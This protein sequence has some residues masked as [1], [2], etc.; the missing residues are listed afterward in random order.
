MK[1]EFFVE[2]KVIVEYAAGSVESL[3][4]QWYAFKMQ[5]KHELAS[6]TTLSDFW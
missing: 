3:Q 1:G 2:K 6:V 5:I 4:G